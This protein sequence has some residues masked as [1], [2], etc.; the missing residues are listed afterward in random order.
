MPDQRTLNSVFASV[1]KKTELWSGT[2]DRQEHKQKLTEGYIPK[3]LCVLLHKL[4]QKHIR[5]P[6][7]NLKNLNEIC[8]FLLC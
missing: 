2:P 1:D 3:P 4:K 5:R 6:A 8:A 7:D